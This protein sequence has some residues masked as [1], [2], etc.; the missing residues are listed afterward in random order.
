MTDPNARFRRQAQREARSFLR[1]KGYNTMTMERSLRLVV[2]RWRRFCR[3][4]ARESGAVA[5]VD[6]LARKLRR[7]HV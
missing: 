7:D 5:V 3:L 6:W 1:S 4:F 2:L